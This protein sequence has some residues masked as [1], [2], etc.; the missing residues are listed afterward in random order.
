MYIEELIDSYY[1]INLLKQKT[2]G[3]EEQIA[4]EFAHHAI[5]QHML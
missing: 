4:T 5:E 1:T 2:L 3:N